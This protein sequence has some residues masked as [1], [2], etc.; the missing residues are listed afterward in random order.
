MRK[1]PKKVWPWV[2][3]GVGALVVV[4]AIGGGTDDSEP[5]TAVRS[6]TTAA[7]TP[8]AL[9]PT[10]EP[11]TPA[12]P[13]RITLPE[14]AGRNGKIV[15]DELT[16][17]GLTNVSLASVDESATVVLILQNWTAVAIEPGPGTVVGAD[18][19]VVL[20]LTK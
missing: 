5:A 1:K 13:A 2:A 17:M 14:V 19:T 3:G 11:T 8:F 15:M 12:P 4:G 10:P 9:A 7:T 6:A 20:K 18:D 16:A